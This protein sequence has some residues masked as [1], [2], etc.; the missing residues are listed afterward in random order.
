MN[1]FHFL[2]ITEEEATRFVPKSHQDPHKRHRRN[3]DLPSNP[4]PD[5]PSNPPSTLPTQTLT[6]QS[7]VS[8]HTETIVTLN[9]GG[10]MVPPNEMEGVGHEFEK[11]GNNTTSSNTNP[12]TSPP[13][14]KQTAT[15]NFQ[16]VLSTDTI[17]S[18]RAADHEPTSLKQQTVPSFHTDPYPIYNPED[19]YNDYDP[20]EFGHNQGHHVDNMIYPDA[21]PHDH[22][23]D[24]ELCTIVSS[25]ARSTGKALYKLYQN[26]C[27]L[28]L[29][30]FKHATYLY[31]ARLLWPPLWY[32]ITE[33]LHLYPCR[34]YST[35]S[36]K[37][38]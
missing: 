27:Y 28:T 18:T 14:T 1:W 19:A 30:H 7:T 4:A 10:E 15:P 36:L 38:L 2:D 21:Y 33:S 6:Q 20:D 24:E 29:P 3:H 17:P 23:D 8:P 31:T 35:A 26:Y 9:A 37:Y 12:P 32:P 34:S 13:D 22:D 16:P 11:D 25:W 5:T